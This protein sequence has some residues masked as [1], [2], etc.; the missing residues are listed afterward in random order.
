MTQDFNQSAI[1][2]CNQTSVDLLRYKI[3]ASVGFKYLVQFLKKCRYF[4]L[5]SNS[6]SGKS[7]LILF[8]FPFHSW[9]LM[10]LLTSSLRFQIAS[11]FVKISSRAMDAPTDIIVTSQH[12]YKAC[13]VIDDVILRVV[14]SSAKTNVTIFNQ[15]RYLIWTT[16]LIKCFS[17]GLPLCNRKW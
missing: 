7:Y 4:L 6:V 1:N 3:T 15:V 16:L 12:S 5:Q 9:W 2:L 8:R 14:Q 11:S 17:T 10:A 13:D